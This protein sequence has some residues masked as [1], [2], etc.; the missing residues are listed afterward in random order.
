MHVIPIKVSVS[1]TYEQV[2]AFAG[3]IQSGPRLFL[4]TAFGL[5][6]V[7]GLFT[8]DLTGNVYALPAPLTAV[9]PA[10][11]ATATTP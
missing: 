11:T 3:A 8:G 1:G 5:S 6:S 4:V 10:N 9:I 7:K 2:M